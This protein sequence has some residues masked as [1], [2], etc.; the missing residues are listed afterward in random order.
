MCENVNCALV[1]S[2]LNATL[3]YVFIENFQ[4]HLAPKFINK[5]LNIDI[6]RSLQKLHVSCL[7]TSW[8]FVENVVARKESLAFSDNL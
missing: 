3:Y 6:K 7:W 8:S 1:V 5:Y 2:P 4:K